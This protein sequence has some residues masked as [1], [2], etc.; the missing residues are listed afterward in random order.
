MNSLETLY[1]SKTKNFSINYFSFCR[2]ESTERLIAQPIY[3]PH[4]FDTKTF[5]SIRNINE[6]IILYID[7]SSFVTWN[8]S[9]GI[10]FQNLYKKIILLKNKALRSVVLK[11]FCMFYP[12]NKDDY[13]IYSQYIKWCSF[14]KKA[15]ETIYI[16][17][18]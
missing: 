14:I 5:C 2:W 16:S 12:F 18:N 1:I 9:V 7:T 11:L 15:K 6:I 3:R 10:N 8:I 4:Y 17:Y 13:Q